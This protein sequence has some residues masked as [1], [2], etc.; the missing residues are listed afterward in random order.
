MTIHSLTNDTTFQLP[1]EVKNIKL[2]TNAAGPKGAQVITHVARDKI[3]THQTK[4][5][6]FRMKTEGDAT[7][8]L[9]DE[10][11]QAIAG[12]GGMGAQGGVAGQPAALPQVVFEKYFAYVNDTS[13]VVQTDILYDEKHPIFFLA[14]N[15]Y[16]RMPF[17]YRIDPG[18]PDAV[19]PYLGFTT[20]RVLIEADKVIGP[21][22]IT[23]TV[24]NN[25]VTWNT[26][27]VSLPTGSY[28][29]ND[30][31]ARIT[32]IFQT[33][34]DRG[35]QIDYIPDT[36]KLRI[37]TPY[38]VRFTN[39]TGSIWSALGFTVLT[40]IPPG[41]PVKQGQAIPIALINSSLT[42]DTFPENDVDA[43]WYTASASAYENVIEL[44][45]QKRDG[46]DIYRYAYDQTSGIWTAGKKIRSAFTTS[47][48]TGVAPVYAEES[49]F[50][51]STSGSLS[52]SSLP[53]RVASV[54]VTNDVPLK[55]KNGATPFFT[56]EA[57][58][59]FA[60]IPQ[61]EDEKI[62]EN[63]TFT[64]YRE[65]LTGRL[66]CKIKDHIDTADLQ[67][68]VS[69]KIVHL[70]T[71]TALEWYTAGATTSTSTLPIVGQVFTALAVTV[72]GGT[73][74]TYGLQEWVG[75]SILEKDIWYHLAV[76]AKSRNTIT[77]GL[78]DI[79]IQ[80]GMVCSG[81]NIDAY[82]LVKSDLTLDPE[83]TDLSL[84]TFT[85]ESSEINLFLNGI[86]EILTVD[87]GVVDWSAVNI[88]D[89][90][91]NIG[92]QKPLI[93]F[94]KEKNTSTSSDIL[95][96]A[97]N[98]EYKYIVRTGGVDIHT[99]DMNTTITTSITNAKKITMFGTKVYLYVATDTDHK[100]K[101]YTIG[102]NGSLIPVTGDDTEIGASITNITMT[103]DYVYVVISGKIQTWKIE[104]DGSL[105]SKV[106]KDLANADKIVIN[107]AGTYAYVTT[108]TTLYE[109]TITNGTLV[110]TPTPTQ[111]T[112][113]V[114]H[115]VVTDTYIYTID[116]SG[117]T[118]YKTGL[119]PVVSKSLT[120][121]K[122]IA[123]DLSGRI[124]VS[125]TDGYIHFYRLTET[126]TIDTGRSYNT[127]VG[128]LT[129]LYTDEK[130]VWITS[131][132][133]LKK[134]II[135][136]ETGG[137]VSNLRIT[138]E[139]VYQTNF[140]PSV[141]PLSGLSSTSLLMLCES[142]DLIKNSASDS[143]I[144]FYED[145]NVT[146]NLTLNDTSN[147]TLTTAGSYIL[148][149][150]Y[151]NDTENNSITINDNIYPLALT[152][153]K[154]KFKQ[155]IY[156]NQ[157]QP[158]KKSVPS[159]VVTLSNIRLKK[160]VTTHIGKGGVLNGFLHGGQVLHGG[161]GYIG[162][163]S[164]G[165]LQPFGSGGGSSFPL[166]TVD[167][168]NTDSQP[169]GA[170]LTYLNGV[171]LITGNQYTT[172][173]ANTPVFSDTNAPQTT[174]NIVT[175]GQNVFLAGERGTTTLAT[176]DGSV[177]TDHSGP[178]G[179]LWQGLSYS[180]EVNLFL[181]VTGDGDIWT[182]S[183][184]NTTDWQLKYASGLTTSTGGKVS[185]VY[186]TSGFVIINDTTRTVIRSNKSVT[187]WSKTENALPAPGGY[188]GLA[189]HAGKIVAVTTSIAATSTD[190]G[191]TWVADTS[192]NLTG[193]GNIVD[194][195][196]GQLGF[197][198]ITTLGYVYTRTE[199]VTDGVTVVSWTPD[200]N[201]ISIG[202]IHGMTYGGG[203]YLVLGATRY[204]L[205]NTW[206]IADYPT[207][208]TAPTTDQVVTFGQG[209]FL[210]DTGISIGEYDTAFYSAAISDDLTKIEITRYTTDGLKT[211]NDFLIPADV[212]YFVVNDTQYIPLMDL[213]TA[214]LNG[215]PLLTSGV[216]TFSNTVYRKVQ[217][218]LVG[219]SGGGSDQNAGG[220]GAKVII[221]GATLSG[222]IYLGTG[223]AGSGPGPMYP[224]GGATVL[225]T[226]NEDDNNIS[227]GFVVAGGGGGAGS[228]G[229]GGNAAENTGQKGQD[230]AG[231][232]N[233]GG[234]DEIPGTGSIDGAAKINI[235]DTP[236][237]LPGTLPSISNGGGG[238]G[239]LTGGGT[240]LTDGGGGGGGS[241]TEGINYMAISYE[242]ASIPGT[243]SIRIVT[244]PQVVLDDARSDTTIL[245]LKQ[246]S[247][248][249]DYPYS[250]TVSYVVKID[251]QSNVHITGRTAEL[252]TVTFFNGDAKQY[253]TV[254]VIEEETL[255]T[256]IF[257][258][259]PPICFHTG[260]GILTPSG[261]VPVEKLN[262]GDLVVTAQG[263]TV[264]ICEQATFQV[265]R[266]ECP[267]F[268]LKAD[269]LA[270]GLPLKD[271]YLSHNH[272]FKY[273]GH[274]RHMKCSPATYEKSGES[275]TTPITYHHL[276][277]PDY[278]R[279]TLV[280]EGVE[281][282]SAFKESRYQRMGWL[283][284][285]TECIPLKCER[286][287]F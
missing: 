282:E 281:V 34:G 215:K 75:T 95:D 227:T 132:I 212:D 62:I 265:A 253:E 250:Q 264:P 90:A 209:L 234:S 21:G 161:Q 156:M 155:A 46:T 166:A 86:K 249:P 124:Y 270:T 61:A 216:F 12:A 17:G 224:G 238:G 199:T 248:P 4:N 273:A 11:I 284:E 79:G 259:T 98:G 147:L 219:G 228:N 285:E 239:G 222:E 27:R 15:G 174:L 184:I 197:K 162:G 103:N 172:F 246:P 169:Q 133:N 135:N 87:T 150:D 127:G 231:S 119:T 258:K 200:T 78:N 139:P 275:E 183:D 134:Y 47:T 109:Y 193:K 40:L 16:L 56:V 106:E 251:A 152:S 83:P 182:N 160:L 42:A 57:W 159:S 77:G 217:V 33:Q 189:T 93:T 30:L 36:Q 146:S 114:T 245:Y 236:R 29:L 113:A 171:T 85:F 37:N 129:G 31:L 223:I 154:F 256:H 73:C 190:G 25:R 96:V 101:G 165:P 68:G 13:E 271:L 88:T 207:G 208:F 145:V 257:G 120:N 80:A 278:F 121:A 32:T 170:T 261:Y 99:A 116:T 58:V 123:V 55:L 5:I 141:E 74:V 91:L 38:T 269:G 151:E 143:L 272:A 89:S 84:N 140:L 181:G 196:Y 230:G 287:N 262:T 168:I 220:K 49:P 205:G 111:Q 277:L 35:F 153:G 102:A 43:M 243:G 26:Q 144:Q 211:T 267:L 118:I 203:K 149:F 198:I 24:E 276:Y 142:G 76:V 175:Y 104:L 179:I 247:L 69:Y 28:T 280:A 188:I 266:K 185:I 64:F 41:P 72:T 131:G 20:S 214:V 178:S 2:T 192:P 108:G 1:P 52:F 213:T 67:V 130:N 65:G 221:R 252:E 9:T 18:T 191:A 82:A 81:P 48:P 274:W 187:R 19:W 112:V 158:I 195:V 206:S 51:F 115:L 45:G 235:G 44:L 173:D 268:C 63:D 283:C 210:T 263:D 54:P 117:V 94:E 240:A 50:L 194:V 157:T 237:N 201:P 148:S 254:V 53:E 255:N 10:K 6:N 23:L 3:T 225:W 163:L 164:A 202:T 60:N 97:L 110:D 125:T 100:I 242:T 66:G 22:P 39:P 7:F 105:N 126:N 229:N 286:V 138:H 233:S 226:L 186:G 137:N 107:P 177:W 180:P 71:L 136:A 232:P 204:A 14:D 241:G 218:E 8:V 260:T 244:L 279:S 167:L 128:T 59:K 176:F 122:Y 70:G 92:I